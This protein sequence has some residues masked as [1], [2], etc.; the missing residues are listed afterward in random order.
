MSIAIPKFSD[1]IEKA[2]EAREKGA[3]GVVRSALAIYYADTEGLNP[4]DLF[5]LIPKYLDKS[6]ENLR[7]WPIPKS[8]SKNHSA[9]V[10]P[11]ISN[12]KSQGL[13]PEKIVLNGGDGGEWLYRYSLPVNRFLW[14]INCT[15][16]DTKGLVWSQF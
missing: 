4:H 9:L 8:I 7:P 10:A 13:P 14:T 16:L 2:R 11:G 6:L 12:M 15:H 3:F 5:G 1:L